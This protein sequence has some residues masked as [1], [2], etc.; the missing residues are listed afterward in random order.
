MNAV[1]IDRA[2]AWVIVI[3]PPAVSSLRTFQAGAPFGTPHGSGMS[4]LVYDAAWLGL[5]CL[6]LTV[7]LIGRPFSRAVTRVNAFSVD[8]NW[9]PPEPPYLVS[10]PQLTTVSPKFLELRMYLVFWPIPLTAPVVGS[11]VTAAAPIV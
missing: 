3:W 7:V 4:A 1:L 11:S 8:P 2:V 6:A 10:T 5:A 9:N